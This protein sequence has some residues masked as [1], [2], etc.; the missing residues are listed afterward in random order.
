MLKLTGKKIFT[1]LRSKILYIKTYDRQSRGF[2]TDKCEGMHVPPAMLVVFNM[3]S[4]CAS[5]CDRQRRELLSVLNCERKEKLCIDY[6]LYI[7][8]EQ[9]VLSL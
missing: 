4:D 5:K 3:C 7:S 2:V 8:A 6:R 1:I 9:H